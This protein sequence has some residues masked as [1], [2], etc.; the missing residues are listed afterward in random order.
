M[1]TFRASSSRHGGILGSGFAQP[2]K[3]TKESFVLPE[4]FQIHPGQ[5]QVTEGF[6]KYRSGK[7]CLG[8]RKG[9]LGIPGRL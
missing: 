7:R 6:G 3:V 9:C 8:V 4:G 2:Q 5:G 1:R